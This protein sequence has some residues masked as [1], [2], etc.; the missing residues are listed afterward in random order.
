MKS[1]FQQKLALILPG[2]FLLGFNIGTGSVTTMAKTGADYGMNLLW[3]LVASCLATYFMIL[4][5]SRYTLVTGET[6]L[7]AFK[8]HIH[9]AMGIFFILALTF[10]VAGSVMGVMGIV[11]DISS[12][13][14]E[15]FIEG[16]I[17]PVYFAA[18]FSALVFII[19]W[20]GET[21]FFER[22][23]AVMVA[24]M[25][26]C[27]LI[28]FFIMTPP[29]SAFL[30]GLVP[31]LPEV[32]EGQNKGPYIVIASMVGTTVSSA[33]FIVRTTL[34]KEAGWKIGDWNIQRRDAIISVVLM[35]LVSM[36]IMAAAAGTLYPAGLVLNE[37]SQMITLLEPLA[38][39]MAVA[40]FAFGIIAAGVSS[41]FPNVLLLPWLLC[42][43]NQ[44][45]RNMKLPKYRLMVFGISLL[46]L[47]VP[48]FNARPVFVMIVSQALNSIVLPLTVG[49]IMFL[50]NKKSLMG[51][52]KLS[53]IT[54]LILSL[55]FVFALFTSYLSIT[56]I[57]A[58]I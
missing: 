10:G 41:Q 3:T 49:C 12:V 57:F 56:A 38:G 9:P 35:F 30:S 45:E 51:K 24:I 1:K 53:T 50:G 32:P 8:K 43:Y 40:I 18:F 47:V 31:S 20:N 5:Y 37:A 25:G 19:F 52:Y 58:Q 23:L 55:V 29:L 14:S 2:I 16:G 17:S 22:A 6:A 54:N 34:V 33:L 44:S 39:S 15:S 26:A 7:Q 13:W 27:F 36:T 42:D 28:N 4:S 46:G 11:A 21:Q 48:I